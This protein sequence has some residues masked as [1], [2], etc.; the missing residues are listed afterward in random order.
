MNEPSTTGARLYRAAWVLPIAGPPIRDGWVA[1]RDGRVTAVGGGRPPASPETDDLGAVALLPGLVN[2]HTHLELSALRGRVPPAASMPVW[3][4]DLLAARRLEA[5][6]VPPIVE[7]IGEAHASG[8]ILVGD[9]SNSLA[10]VGPLAASPLLA[11]VFHEL[12]G[13]KPGRPGGRRAPRR[14]GAARAA[15]VGP[16][17]RDARRARAVFVVAG[18]VS[19]RARVDGPLR[20]AG[21]QRARGRVA[22][23][24]A[25]PARRERALAHAARLR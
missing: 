13:F 2:A 14:R 5:P 24:G 18:P 17:A 16:R 8:T 25:V 4:C 12:L 19:R 6:P 9:V 11:V 21:D 20:G 15:G 1:V 7:A 10:T 23:G 22:R 3:V